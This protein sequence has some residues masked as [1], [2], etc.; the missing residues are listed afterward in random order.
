MKYDPESTVRSQRENMQ[1]YQLRLP[2]ETLR[3]IQ[4]LRVLAGVKVSEELRDLVVA[5]VAE[6]RD[7]IKQ[8]AQEY[9]R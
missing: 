3:D 9:S 5:Y 8:A 4:A 7:L 1:P 6:R 2:K